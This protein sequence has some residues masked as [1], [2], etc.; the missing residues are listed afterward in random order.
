M[1]DNMTQFVKKQT[2]P[3]D[4]EARNLLSVA[5]KNKIGSKRTSWRILNGLERD[6]KE[7]L[8][9]ASDDERPKLE[10]NLSKLRSYKESIEAEMMEI[11]VAVTELIDNH[12][13]KYDKADD[14]CV[15]YCKM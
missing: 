4:I 5:Y 9:S 1:V 14:S 8:E 6:K 12:L 10:K 2:M 15:F 7:K 11:H 13:N 3:I